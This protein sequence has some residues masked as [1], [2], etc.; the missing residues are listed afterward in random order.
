MKNKPWAQKLLSDSL[1]LTR[2]GVLH[3]CNIIFQIGDAYLDTTEYSSIFLHQIQ[4]LYEKLIIDVIFIQ[5]QGLDKLKSLQKQLQI[6]CKDLH[7]QVPDFSFNDRVPIFCVYQHVYQQ[8]KELSE[9]KYKQTNLCKS[10]GW[11]P[12]AVVNEVND[13]R[14][15]VETLE[16]EIFERE[17]IYFQLKEEIAVI[18]EELGTS[19]NFDLANS[20]VKITDLDMKQLQTCHNKFKVKYEITKKQIADLTKKIEELWNKLEVDIAERDAFRKRNSGNCLKMLEVMEMEV[21]RL[22]QIRK[23]QIKTL[24]EKKR[25][26]LEKMWEK[27]HCSHNEKGQ[28]TFFNSEF[29]NEN[30]FDLYEREIDKWK[31]YYEQNKDILCLLDKYK[32]IW[33]E[34]LE[35]N[36]GGINRYK[37]RGGQLLLEEKKRNQFKKRLFQIEKTLQEL[38]E[39]YLSREG[40]NFLTHGLTIKEY[41]KKVRQEADKEI[42]IK[43]SNNKLI[44]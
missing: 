1:E 40:F 30:L 41:I 3:W 38:S 36:S 13:L 2:K 26:E 17:E 35:M 34:H 43:D 12:L 20:E 15:Y 18:A 24:I 29:Y 19:L 21:S 11:E 28:F 5:H 7:L 33:T 9:L 10:L 42:K 39:V 22:E 27:C 32:K 25:K 37:N 6:L 31:L 23:V 8:I 14:E 16:N 44:Q 4:N